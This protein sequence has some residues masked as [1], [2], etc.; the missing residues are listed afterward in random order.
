[1]IRSKFGS[2]TVDPTA[3]VDACACD[4]K[5]A[6]LTTSPVVG[7]NA[8]LPLLASKY[9]V[10]TRFKVERVAEGDGSTSGFTWMYQGSSDG[11]P[12]EGLRGTTYLELDADGKISFVKEVCEPVFK[13]GSVTADLL[14]AVTAEAAKELELNGKHPP[15][16]KPST[17]STASEV[18]EYLWKE[19]YPK[20]A[21]ISEALRLFSENIVYEDFNYEVPFVG[22]EDVAA[23]LEEFD[24]PGIEFIPQR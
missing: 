3:I 8:V 18:V 1:M 6:D 12:Q 14:K 19:A 5:W 23:F 10:G 20:G 24:F 17:P 9:P 4:V 11:S 13:P 16:Y 21:E 7:R 2:G 22:K 15:T